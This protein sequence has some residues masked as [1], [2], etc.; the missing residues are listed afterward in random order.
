[1]VS[2]RRNVTGCECRIVSGHVSSDALSSTVPFSSIPI[3]SIVTFTS[4]IAHH[5]AHDIT[6]TPPIL[7]PRL[8]SDLL[9]KNI[10]FDRRH[11]GPPLPN[12]RKRRLVSRSARMARML[13]SCAQLPSI[14]NR[15]MDRFICECDALG[16]FNVKIIIRLL[17]K[18][19]PYELGG[20]SLRIQPT[21]YTERPP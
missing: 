13:P 21:A 7:P 11:I 8:N 16:E 15:D 6:A 5:M 12:P 10:Q 1:M 9:F 4:H 19:W 17:K 14:W 3:E 18:K 2:S 20:V